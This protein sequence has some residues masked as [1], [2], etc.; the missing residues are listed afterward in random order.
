[1]IRIEQLAYVVAESR[2]PAQWQLF[3]E[4]VVGLMARPAPDGGLYLKADERDFRIAI[5]PGTQDRYYASG[6]QLADEAAYA[7]AL[8]SLR[9][10]GVAVEEG[11]AELCCAR[12]AQQLL[13]VH[14]PSGNRHE[15]FWGPQ[16]D[17]QRFCSPVGVPAFLTGEL[18]MGHT[19]LP[20]PAFDAS[21]SFFRDVFGFGLADLYRHRNPAAPE[22]GAQRI[23]FTHCANGR[24]HSLA[25]F[26]GEVPSGCVHIMLEL[27][28]MDA[29]GRAYDR[30]LKHQVPLMATLGRHVNDEVTSFYLRTPA[31]FALELGYGGRVVDWSRHSVFEATAVS[32][33]G[34]DFSVGFR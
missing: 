26:E 25:L 20:A 16:S 33:W 15:L 23:Y 17:F 8:A 22:A 2:E 21:W 19:V 6:W 9:A 18:G 27:P 24:H 10:A 3:G 1:M 13:V 5:V 34:H 4:Q 30:M 29:L 14:D 7:E 28:D 31:G 32:L 12:R 11:S